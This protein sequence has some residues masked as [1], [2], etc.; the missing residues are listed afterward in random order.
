MPFPD[1]A[2]MAHMP[3]I[4][5]TMRAALPFGHCQFLPILS[6]ARPFKSSRRL[7][8][9]NVLPNHQ[10]V[11]GNFFLSLCPIKRELTMAIVKKRVHLAGGPRRYET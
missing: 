8:T 10:A 11:A 5:P 3:T 4:Y 1:A 7:N 6:T 2:N 9:F